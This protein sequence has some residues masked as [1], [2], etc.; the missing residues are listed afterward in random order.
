MKSSWYCQECDQQI[1]SGDREHHEADG[2]EV[3]G[4][5]R[6][7]RLLGNDP[8]NMDLR[9]QRGSADGDEVSD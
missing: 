8:W 4:V 9:N 5:L 6:P 1:D 7:D 3:R 2:H